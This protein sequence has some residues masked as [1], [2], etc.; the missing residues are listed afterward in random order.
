M[1]IARF[2]AMNSNQVRCLELY[3][4]NRKS[5]PTLRDSFVLLDH[6]RG[7]D[8]QVWF[9]S[10]VTSVEPI[11]KKDKIVFRI[12]RVILTPKDKNREQLTYFLD[13]RPGVGVNPN[14]SQWRMS[15][16]DK[17]LPAPDPLLAPR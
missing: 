16:V 7:P 8:E 17:P 15:I 10:V 4:V 5:N 9:P 12:R 2:G 13:Y 6:D 3:R 14:M 11:V 1:M